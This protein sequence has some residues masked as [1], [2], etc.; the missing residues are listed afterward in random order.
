MQLNRIDMNLLVVLET[1]YS[2]GG[3]TRAADKLHLT[4]PAL[5]H[6]LARLREL[7][8]DPLFVREGRAMVP[9]PLARKLIEPLRRSLRAMETALNEVQRFD[10]ATTQRRFA[11]GLRDVLEATVLPPLM[12]RISSM[13]PQVD[14]AAL[15]LERRELEAELASG[16]LDAALDV[17]LP[18]GDRV[19]HQRLALDKLVVVA[20]RNH[21]VVR[22]TLDLKTYLD[23]GHVAVSSR[24]AG[25][26]LE[27]TELAR[28]GLQRRIR[29]RCQHYFAACQVVARSDLLL[30]MPERYAGVANQ[31]SGNRILPLPFKA[32]SLDAYLYWHVN[33]DQEPASCWLREQLVA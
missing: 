21:P 24:R 20:R 7:F 33:V 6:S 30:T 3:I 22:K 31:T 23:L 15:R 17:L 32:P 28:R 18:H 12:K 19:K 27:D 13:A 8:K 9:T 5:S 11:I 26:G 25:P 29:L 2:E 4:Q 16:T 1:I 10:P 14:V